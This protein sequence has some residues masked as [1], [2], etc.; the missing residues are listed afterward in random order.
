MFNQTTNNV[1]AELIA[2][3]VD[4]VRNGAATTNGQIAVVIETSLFT[5]EFGGGWQAKVFKTASAA[6]EYARMLR[7]EYFSLVDFAQIVGLTPEMEKLMNEN[8]KT[9][10][11]GKVKKLK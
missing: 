4:A 9:I 1:N 7:A 10:K 11:N 3:R 6:R 8:G 5:N 2:I